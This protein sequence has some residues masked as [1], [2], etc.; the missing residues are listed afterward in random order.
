M[1]M[2]KTLAWGGAAVLTT[3]F[4]VFQMW[5]REE[6]APKAA[7]EPD[8]FGFIKPVGHAAGAGDNAI[9]A[10]GQAGMRGPDAAEQ[11][12]SY[13][14]EQPALRDVPDATVRMAAVQEAAQ[15]MRSQGASEDE[16]YRMRAE[17]LSPDAAARMAGMERDEHAWKARVDAYLAERN[18]LLGG[19]TGIYPEEALQ[20]LRNARFTADEQKRLATYEGAGVPH[21]TMD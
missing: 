11:A 21:L 14:A 13:A 9:A 8:L 16:V 3:A 1:D 7:A 12:I 18:A 17:Q 15:R 19:N 2:R 5:P 10:P 6:P 20:Q 4:F